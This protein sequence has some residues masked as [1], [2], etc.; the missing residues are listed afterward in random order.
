M[1]QL[2]TFL[3]IFLA[4]STWRCD[5][6][7]DTIN[8]ADATK[9]IIGQWDG[10]LL[11]DAGYKQNITLDITTNTSC[12]FTGLMSFEDSQTI[13]IV[14][15]TVDKYG[16]VKFSETDYFY[17]GGEYTKCVG[18]GWSNPC[19][20]YPTGRYRTGT[21]Y[22]DARLRNDNTLLNGDF[23]MQS[24]SWYNGLRGNFL[25]EKVG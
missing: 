25:I 21:R 4:S 13:F 17:D 22:E 24:S 3:F 12:V 11:Y 20:R 9:S 16:W 1:K 18:S 10:R 2:I 8:C 5:E 19:N 6:P 15:G 14:S 23:Y 7:E